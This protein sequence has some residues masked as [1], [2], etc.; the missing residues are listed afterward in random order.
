MAWLLIVCYTLWITPLRLLSALGDGKPRFL[1]R[2]WGIGVHPPKRRRGLGIPGGAKALLPL[3]PAARWL[4]RH[5]RIR[6]VAVSVQ[7]GGDA[8]AAA[9]LTGFLRAL[10]GL[11][12][13]AHI[14]CTPRF[15]DS[16]AWRAQCI[17]D[18]RLGTIGTAALM[19]LWLLWRARRKKGGNA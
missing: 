2:I 19:G 15:G 10:G 17:A 9:L 5:I 4:I 6:Q 11:V 13:K 16:G 1:L 18:V 14:R 12:P 3:L 7:A 8:A